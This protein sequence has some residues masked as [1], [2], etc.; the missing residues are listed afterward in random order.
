MSYNP[1]N[2]NGQTTMA[3]SS[4]VTIASDQSA[5]P[6]SAGALPLPTGAAT[7][8]HQIDGTQ[9]SQI[10]DG[11]GNVI[12][13]TSNALNVNIAGGSVGGSV[14]YA[15]GATAATATG[16]LSMGKSGNTLKATQTDTNGNVRIDLSQTSANATAIKVDGSAATQPVSGT[17]TA[18]IGTT[19]GI[20]L[21]S[22]V[23][24]ILITQGSTTSGQK[25]TLSQ[26]A[27][28]TAA[29]TYTT[30]QTSPISIDTSGN[31]RTSVNNTVTVS[32]TVTSTPT[33]TQ[34]VNVSQVSGS[35]IATAATGIQKVGITDGTGTA[36]T[37]TS[38]ALDINIKSGQSLT[39]ATADEAAWTAGTSSFAPTGG[40][41]NDSAA[42]LTSGQ[43]GTTRVT[44]NRALHSNLRNSAG[45]EIATSSNPL[46]IDPTGTTTQPVSGT[47]GLSAGTNNIGGVEL[48]DSGGTNKLSVNASGQAAV[49]PTGGDLTSGNQTVKLTD[50]TNTSNVGLGDASNGFVY[51]G[52]GRL[53]QTFNLSTTGASTSYDV[54]NYRWIS[55]QFTAVGGATS[56]T[57]FQCSNDNSNFISTAL[58]SSGSVAVNATTAA[59]ASAGVGIYHGPLTGRYF[60]L[61]VTTLPSG[62]V[63]GTI[64]FSTHAGVLS[65]FGVAVSQQSSPWVSSLQPATSGGW[66]ISS[67]TALTNT[68]VAAKASAGQVG[69]HMFYNPNSSVSYIQVFNVA[70]GSV[71]LGTTAPTMVVPIPPGAAANVEWANGI[72][73]GTAISFAATTTA[74]GNT[75]PATA[76]TGFLLYK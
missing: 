59:T 62:S 8:A 40:V 70:S 12:G 30:G 58:A 15:E 3:N 44:N 39:A 4:P 28:T 37:S 9:K 25:G 2:P 60:R 26:G 43:Q 38:N 32:G 20:A 49:T 57:S 7:A 55:I 63:T 17:V 23:N 24:G 13:S 65:S 61:N 66:S 56:S 73:Y 46:R 6:V 48:I 18:N 64:I 19:N 10:V 29:P 35:N 69:G 51:T 75:A 45:T 36:I 22:S 41:F 21:D 72:A 14:Q 52:S 27:V 1:Q 5:V 71:T 67:Q 50:G 76:L 42:A 34:S 54:G 33:G 68:V 47:L 11:T 16:T 31:V 53:T 74:T